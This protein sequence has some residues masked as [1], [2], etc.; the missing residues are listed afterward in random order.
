VFFMRNF[1]IASSLICSAI[2]AHALI[3]REGDK[4]SDVWEASY[5]FS[6]AD[7]GTLH[8][9][10]APDSDQ[11]QDGHT[12]LEESFAGTDP[13][14]ATPFQKGSGRPAGKFSIEP[15]KNEATQRMN[16]HIWAVKGKTYE[17]FVSDTLQD[18]TSAGSVIHNG[19]SGEIAIDTNV[20]IASHA[21]KF[22]RIAVS[23]HDQDG[24]KISNY[25][26]ALLNT[27]MQG[28]LDID[29]DDL[30]DDWERAMIGDLS[31]GRD[32]DQNE[33]GILEFDEYQFDLDPSGDDADK[34]VNKE[35][36]QYDYTR[37]ILATK[38]SALSLT[39]A[40]DAA[41]NLTE[42]SP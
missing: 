10:Q 6:L 7:D 18:W 11:D 39:F 25:E 1:Y 15:V 27:D 30:P 26:E 32:S 40:Y 9:E 37:L 28:N 14:Q 13:T 35:V 23:D 24:D 8:P 2:H 31:R 38:R 22:W 29:G 5:G 4:M 41:G 33:D 36:F 12:N 42:V 16:V 3:D 17:V 21:K 20:S 19:T 34:T